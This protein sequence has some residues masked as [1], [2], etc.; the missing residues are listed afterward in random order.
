MKATFSGTVDILVK[1]YLNGTLAHRLCSACAVG[2]L[3]AH[4]LGTK[5]MSL[6]FL[7]D[8]LAPTPF[9]NSRFESCERV[10]WNEIFMTVG[11]NQNFSMSDA[12]PEAYNQ[13]LMTGY[14]VHDL[15]RIEFAFES[16]ERPE[17]IISQDR[18]GQRSSGY[19]T[20]DEWM[21]NGLCAVVDV[22]VEIHGISLDQK[23]SAKLLFVKS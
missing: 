14:S 10:R 7:G 13:I 18:T 16:C 9:S 12:S 21:F 15:A 3:V 8:D 23:E 19:Y 11:G 2:N 4:A 17:D 22:L 6:R 5:P 1:A 20:D